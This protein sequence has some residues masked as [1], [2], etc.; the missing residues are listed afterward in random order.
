LVGLLV[1][2]VHPLFSSIKRHHLKLARAAGL[3]FLLVC[4]A[5]MLATGDTPFVSK[6]RSETSITSDNPNTGLTLNQAFELVT[7]EAG[8]FLTG[9]S[10]K[11]GKNHPPRR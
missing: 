7:L 9:I 1:A 10:I 11:L 4:A 6:V 2:K 3:S 8:I 5:D